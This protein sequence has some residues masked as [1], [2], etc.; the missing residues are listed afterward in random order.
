[1]IRNPTSEHITKKKKKPTVIQK[2]N[3]P[4]VNSRTIDNSQDML[5]I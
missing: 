3:A 2:D 5:K 1:M 4:S